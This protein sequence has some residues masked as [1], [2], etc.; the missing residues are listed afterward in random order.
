[1][2]HQWVSNTIFLSRK[3]RHDLC[4]TN[5]HARRVNAVHARAVYAH[6][7][8]THSA[9]AYV[10]HAHTV[11]THA[12]HCMFYIRINSVMPTVAVG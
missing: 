11:H 12:L 4:M 1:M 6:T 9:H 10:G 7:A 8:H 2:L 3:N 5:A